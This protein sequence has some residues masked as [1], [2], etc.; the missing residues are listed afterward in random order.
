[1]PNSDFCVSA[2]DG[3]QCSNT[4]L[5]PRNVICILSRL[6]HARFVKFNRRLARFYL[7]NRVIFFQKR[8]LTNNTNGYAILTRE[9]QRYI[10][11]P[12]EHIA[13][14]NKPQYCSPYTKKTKHFST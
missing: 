1:M 3:E 11:Q 13:Q 14:Y 4:K 6:N 5:M 7:R 9:P 8:I 2:D 10:A 12:D